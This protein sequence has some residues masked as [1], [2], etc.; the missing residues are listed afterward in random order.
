MKKLLSAITVILI[1]S[2][3]SLAEITVSDARSPEQLK[4]EGYSSVLIQAVQQEAGEYN[5][6]PT[7]RW[8]RFGFKVWNYVDPVS[9]QARDKER[10]DIKLYNHYEDL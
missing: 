10:H 7:N 5:P 9:P 6:A 2:N 1:T 3:I 4:K 8:Q